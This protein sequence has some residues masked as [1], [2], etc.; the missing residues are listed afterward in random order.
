MAVICVKWPEFRILK[1]IT[2]FQVGGIIFSHKAYLKDKWNGQE[3][4]RLQNVKLQ[5]FERNTKVCK[6]SLQI[7]ANRDVCFGKSKIERFSETINY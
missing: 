1:W 6:V 3:F 4:H 7:L 5:M 2:S